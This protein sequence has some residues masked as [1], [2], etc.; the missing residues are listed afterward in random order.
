MNQTNSGLGGSIR[1][2]FYADDAMETYSFREAARDVWLV[3]H[4]GF[5]LD[6]YTTQVDGET[7]AGISE[8]TAGDVNVVVA[9]NKR[10][11]KTLKESSLLK[12]GTGLLVPRNMTNEELRA[13]A[14]HTAA[15]HPESTGS[16]SRAGLDWSYT[17]SASIY[18]GADLGQWLDR[19]K[20]R[21]REKRKRDVSRNR[22]VRN[23]RVMV[24]DSS[25]HAPD[26][27]IILKYKKEGW[28]VVMLDSGACKPF[29]KSCI[30]QGDAEMIADLVAE[31]LVAQACR[32]MQC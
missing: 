22:S 31:A 11:Y 7:L 26:G 4:N 3:R 2:H 29:R 25:M 9:V 28:F 10:R 14:E 18:V 21:W 5:L 6:K 19:Q 24:Q 17:N 16:Q 20:S 8:N 13:A 32:P 1:V 27:G 23:N 15:Q 30:V 12:P